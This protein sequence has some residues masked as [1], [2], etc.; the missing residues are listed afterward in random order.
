MAENYAIIAGNPL[1]GLKLVGPFATADEA[2]QYATANMTS[3][4]VC[5]T[6]MQR[7]M[8]EGST[9]THILMESNHP[10]DAPAMACWLLHAQIPFEYVPRWRSEGRSVIT[11]YQFKISRQYE[12]QVMKFNDGLLEHT[13]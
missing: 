8:R 5:V 4:P 10:I 9:D 13:S 1:D 3:T 7:P 12:E 6:K 2:T 11:I